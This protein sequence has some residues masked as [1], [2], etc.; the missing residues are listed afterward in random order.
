MALHKIFHMKYMLVVVLILCKDASPVYRET[1]TLTYVS[2]IA[3]MHT[4]RD[5]G[6]GRVVSQEE[7]GGSKSLVRYLLK[8]K[9]SEQNANARWGL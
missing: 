6:E 9:S 8:C 5:R 1:S 4:I 2:D 3:D 7:K